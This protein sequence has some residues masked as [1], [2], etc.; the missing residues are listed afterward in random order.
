MA[1]RF[2][3]P[4]V[5]LGLLATPALAQQQQAA[6]GDRVDLLSQ[7][8]SKYH[9]S[10]AA[11]GMTGNGSVVELMTSDDGSWTLVL[12][13]PNGRSCMMAT[14]EGWEQSKARLVGKGA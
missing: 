9:E 3:L 12:S 10:P 13:F 4:L 5:A 7:L 8:K 14:G 11:Y 2:V 1:Y 6:C